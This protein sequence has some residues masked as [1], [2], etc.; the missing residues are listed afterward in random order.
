MSE[1]KK[2][3]KPE[4]PLGKSVAIY[5]RVV[6]VLFLAIFVL[7]LSMMFGEGSSAAKIPFS[8]LSITT[9]TFGLMGWVMSELTAR[10]A[11]RWQD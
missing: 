7:G 8:S 4:R 3:T 6:S 1:E 2:E 10:R 9:T 11:E 5:A